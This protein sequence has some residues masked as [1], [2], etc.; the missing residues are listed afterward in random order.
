MVTLVCASAGAATS[1]DAATATATQAT[2]ATD[3][4]SGPATDAASGPAT[5]PASGPATA[6]AANQGHD[7]DLASLARPFEFP[8]WHITLGAIVMLGLGLASGWRL[9]RRLR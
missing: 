4:A 3:A 2:I 1:T 9:G 5:A 6:T 8:P 7:N